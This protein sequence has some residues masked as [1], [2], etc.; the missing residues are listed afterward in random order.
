MDMDS[1]IKERLKETRRQK[2]LRLLRLVVIIVALV[3]GMVSLWRYVHRPEFAFGHAN[4]SGTNKLTEADIL[5]MAGTGQPMNLFNISFSRVREALKQDVRFHS[6]SVEYKWPNEMKIMVQERE[7][8]LYVAN[9]YRSYVQLDYKGVVLAVSTAIPDAK[10][11]LL[12]GESCGNVFI[13]DAIKNQKV[14]KVLEFHQKLSPEARD[15]IVE[16][17]QD[18]SLGIKLRQR[19]GMLVLLGPVEN[20][21]DKVDLFMTVFHQLKGKNVQAEYIDL[22]FK[23]PYIKL[24]PEAMKEKK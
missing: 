14:L 16:I 5:K 23:K 24:K 3:A 21:M 8:A 13:G 7:P 22:T 15:Q 19:N 20:L 1:S 2:R 4:I 10:A 18:G 17:V 9:S 11:P 6:S 12:I